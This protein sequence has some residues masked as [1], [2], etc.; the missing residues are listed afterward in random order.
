M[1]IARTADLVQRAQELRTG[2]AAL[3]VIQLE[4]AEAIV[5]AAECSG[6]PVILQVSENA[7]LYHSG[8]PVPIAAACLALAR[9]SSMPVALHLD[10]ATSFS[11]CRSA[12]EAGFSSYMIDA[13]SADYETNVQL[14]REAAQWGREQGAW[15]EAELGEVGGKG[16]HA[17][18]ARTDPAEAGRFV[19]ETKV[20]GLAI[21]I[22]SSHAMATQSANLDLRLL[23][24]IRGEVNVPL[25]LH[26][27]SGV[28]DD[29]VRDAISLGITKVNVSTQLNK[30]M[31]SAIR[32]E[33]A[34]D[35]DLIDPRRYLGPARDAIEGQARHLLGLINQVHVRE[36]PD[37]KER[38]TQ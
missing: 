20:D 33:L 34:R 8:D 25:V 22:G 15:T 21:A 38:K 30:A 16:A 3:N 14:T 9:R 23:E 19:E 1:T 18:G 11:L 2:I 31:S 29:S 5:R 36:T 7:L 12:I 37:M 10:H 27:T 4:H 24:S 35:P 6:A 28:P 32:L 13:S 26:G 17:P